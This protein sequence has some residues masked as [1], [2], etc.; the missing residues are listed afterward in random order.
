M[1]ENADIVCFGYKDA[2]TSY[3]LDEEHKILTGREAAIKMFLNDGLDANAV[4]KL[5]RRDL[6]EGIRYPVGKVYEVV[7][8]TYRVLMRAEK[9]VRTNICGYYIE[10][11]NN[12]ITRQNFSDKNLQFTDQAYDV[13]QS[14]KGIDDELAFYAYQ[15]YLYAI[16]CMTEKAIIL[17]NKEETCYR[18]MYSLFQDSYPAIKESKYLQRRKKQ[19]ALLIKFGC[20]GVVW[21]AYICVKMRKQ[22][23]I[24]QYG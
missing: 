2:L 15:F 19:I 4:C 5:Y 9:V 11:R 3:Y 20:Y 1:I 18:T 17:G 12:S 7:P 23:K 16:I 10:T 21:R 13:Y 14:L 6:F 24:E 22:K 8:V